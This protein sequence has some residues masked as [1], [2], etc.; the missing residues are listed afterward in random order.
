MALTWLR[1]LA[2]EESEMSQKRVALALQGGGSHGA[3]TWGVLD[4]LLEEERIDIEALSGAS[5]GAVNAVVL[6]HGYAQGGRE[7]AR[8]AL[9]AFWH[10]IGSTAYS[11][12]VAASGQRADPASKGYLFLARFFSPYQLNPLAAGITSARSE[13]H[14]LCC[15]PHINVSGTGHASGQNN[16]A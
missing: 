14:E 2:F 1:P 10:A 8:R 3:Y 4:R 16:R 7:S 5:A 12:S 6:A 11:M 15:P 13:W 9:D